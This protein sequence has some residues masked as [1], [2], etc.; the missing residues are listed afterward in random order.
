MPAV[1]GEG[2]N[3]KS[4]DGIFVALCHVLD[5]WANG[6]VESMERRRVHCEAKARFAASLGLLEVSSVVTVVD[7]RRAEGWGDVSCGGGREA[8]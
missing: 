2:V 4:I 5:K 1:Q 3:R 6:E 8:S 7:G